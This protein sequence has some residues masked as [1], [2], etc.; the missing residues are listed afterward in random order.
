MFFKKC[1]KIILVSS[2]VAENNLMWYNLVVIR[3]G[4]NK[5]L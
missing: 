1:K 5:S 2:N 3:Y 4:L